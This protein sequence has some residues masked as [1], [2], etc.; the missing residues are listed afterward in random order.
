MYWLIK[1]KFEINENVNYWVLGN[2]KF[3]IVS[4]L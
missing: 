1:K 4:V 3:L 2:I